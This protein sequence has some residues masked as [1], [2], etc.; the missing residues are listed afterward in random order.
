VDSLTATFGAF[1]DPTRRSLLSRL[2]G[3][4]ISVCDLAAPFKISQQAIS[5]H[6]A[7]LVRAGLV[8]KRKHGRRHFCALK[9]DRFKE[10]SDWVGDY[11]QFWEQSFDRLDDYLREIQSKGKNPSGRS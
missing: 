6:I 4:P 2:A 9:A 7:Y 10:A 1:S 5:K 3:G 11:R 8:V